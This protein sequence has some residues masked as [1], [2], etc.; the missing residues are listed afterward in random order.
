M[1]HLV[2]ALLL[3][4]STA[5][6]LRAQS[7]NTVISDVITTATGA[8]PSGTITIEWSKYED[9]SVPRRVIFP[10][11]RTY[12]VTAGA[13][14]I[15]LFPNTA[16]LPVGCYKVSYSL[17][18]QQLTRYWTVPV[19][20]VPVTITTIEGTIPCTP[21]SGPIIAPSQI[22]DAGAQTGQVLAFNGRYWAPANQTGGGSGGGSNTPPYSTATITSSPMV[23]LASTHGMGTKAHGVCWD[24]SGNGQEESSCKWARNPAT[25]D[26]TLTYTTAPG[27]IDIFGFSTIGIAPAAGLTGDI[28]FNNLGSLGGFTLGGDCT[29]NRPN[30][31]C[32]KTGGVPFAPSATTDTTNAANISS[33]LLSTARGGTGAGTFSA[34]SVPFTSVGGQYA[35]D[36][37]NFFW[38]STNKRLGIGIS[39][40]LAGLDVRS[41]ADDLGAGG[42]RIRAADGPTNGGYL[43]LN[44]NSGSGTIATIQ[45]GDN[46]SYQELALNPFGG[47]VSMGQKAT[48]DKG[49]SIFQINATVSQPS[50][51]D[52]QVSVGQQNNAARLWWHYDPNPSLGYAALDGTDPNTNM[53]ISGNYVFLT[54]NNFAVMVTGQSVQ[55]IGQIGAFTVTGD[56]FTQTQ[57]LG[58]GYQSSHGYGWLQASLFG[59]GFKPIQIN[60]VGGNVG[61][62]LCP[63]ASDCSTLPAEILEVG[64]NIK[65]SGTIYGGTWTGTAI[66]EPRGGTNQTTYALG[67]MLYASATNTLSKLAGN[68]SATLK[69]MTQ[70]G[71]GSASAAPAWSTLSGAGIA[72]TANPLS[73]FASTTSAQLL[74]TLSDPTGTGV[75]VFNT[76]PT[77]A[78]NIQVNG[79]VQFSGTTSSFPA[80]KRS[81]TKFIAR[82]ADDS[83]DTTVQAS[84]FVAGGGTPSVG[85][86]GTI[87]TGSKNAAGF[88]TTVT[89]ACT[90]VLTFSGVT[91]T[92]G[93][94]CSITNST[95]AAN[96]FV[97]TASSTTTATFVGTSGSNDIIRFACTPY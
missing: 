32:T 10:G 74:A 45:S 57:R 87:G 18:G 88:I 25:G 54:P 82:L 93:W 17:A 31:T 96:L 9:D 22:S 40:P 67:D 43:I 19:S 5:L 63:A 2:T 90:S 69:V 71:T 28:Q 35:Q 76:N 27:Q 59:T 80:W 48:F 64:G 62:G 14:N 85:T 47:R 92:T 52:A 77:F 83:A 79:L 3:L 37:A 1:R 95:T 84:A 46:A 70:T 91:A 68:T 29:L 81:T 42:I 33:G 34:G 16:S 53:S 7:A 20:A 12:N 24:S 61:I 55:P 6:S 8:H 56:G 78:S 21:Y 49:A 50:G 58:F 89:G 11:R 30:L 75:A 51:V 65:F 41:A 86:C 26:L 4:S 23:I 72:N 97:Q 60:P 44:K 66:T 94:S 38:D 73:Q 13:V 36:N 39:V 15:S